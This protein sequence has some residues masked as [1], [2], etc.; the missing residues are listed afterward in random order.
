MQVFA[1][2]AVLTMLGMIG[3]SALAIRDGR[4]L[5][6]MSRE[7]YRRHAVQLFLGPVGIILLFAILSV[8]TRTVSIPSFTLLLFP[9][10]HYYVIR[11]GV[12]RLSDIDG[13]PY[14]G[15][16]R[17]LAGY[18]L[19]TIIYL[20]TKRTKAPQTDLDIF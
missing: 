17:A 3:S 5:P 16:M 7:V 9:V 2:I 15:F 19:G 4:R 6:P 14:R 20:C 13:R 18:H 1:G 8:T 10:I 11:R 12:Q